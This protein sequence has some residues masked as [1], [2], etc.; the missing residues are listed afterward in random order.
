MYVFNTLA[1]MESCF[2]VFFN[3]VVFKSVLGQLYT[4]LGDSVRLDFP[5]KSRMLHISK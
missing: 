5:I 2:F 4:F 1:E 3:Y